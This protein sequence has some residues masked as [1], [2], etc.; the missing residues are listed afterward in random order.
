[1]RNTEC[2]LTRHNFNITRKKACNKN[3]RQLRSKQ[4]RQAVCKAKSKYFEDLCSKLR[5]SAS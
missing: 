1:M 3:E 5:D 4:Y 2:E